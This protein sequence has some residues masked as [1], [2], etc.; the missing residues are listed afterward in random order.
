[1]VSE[2][3][4]WARCRRLVEQKV[5]WGNSDHWQ[6][7]DFEQLSE[8]ILAETGVSLS[9]T[10]L[11]RLWG[12]V[13][14]DSTPNPTTL[15]TLAQ[16]VGYDNWRTLRVNGSNGR[17]EP[18]LQPVVEE[19]LPAPQSIL[20]PT[21]PRYGRWALAGLIG[22]VVL[23]GMIWGYR[24]R[25][26]TLHYSA[27]SFTSRPVAKGVPNTVVF[28]Y[29]VRDTNADSVFI[30]QSWDPA[31]RFR[32]DKAGRQYTSTYY[33]PGYYRAKLVLN[34]SIV[35]EHDLFIASGGWLGTVDQTPI[36][37]YVLPNR[38]Q[39]PTGEAAITLADLQ[40]L[41]VALT[42]KAPAVS[43]FRVDSTQ[44]A[45][46]DRFVFETAVRSTYNRGDAVCQPVEIV[47]LCTMGAHVIPLSVPG[48]VGELTLRTGHQAIRGKTTDLSGFGVDF[49][50]WVPV[51]YEVAD[52]RVR[53]WIHQKQVYEGPLT[54][55]PGQ[56]TGLRY[57]FKGTGAVQYARLN[58]IPI[59]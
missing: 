20:R 31:L 45:T 12:R 13:R 25:N 39:K 35:R 10:T 29:N 27:V 23:V 22:L 1:M 42:D 4:V 36:P 54:Q 21:P 56:V 38:V 9:V 57:R 47:L 58:D 46:G 7:R 44:L 30:Q 24:K 16:F 48:C 40:S 19:P 26:T 15:D 53:I 49:S 55:S 18:G 14:Y 59:Q 32:V 50:N 3:D 2:E 8:Q 5:G 33:Y 52:K 34:D 28:D 37:L 6:N 11:K 51:R 41:G 43:L 17:S